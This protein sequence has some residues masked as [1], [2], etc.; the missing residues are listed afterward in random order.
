MHFSSKTSKIGDENEE[1]FQ[2]NRM[3]HLALKSVQPFRSY[4]HSKPKKKSIICKMCKICL[5][6]H[7]II[8]LFSFSTY[9]PEL[10]NICMKNAILRNFS[11]KSGSET[12]QNWAK[13]DESS[14]FKHKIIVRLTSLA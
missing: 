7:K 12:G 8:I 6:E 4:V 11:I 5:F 3:V 2:T 14:I 10:N 13:M 9:L 1:F